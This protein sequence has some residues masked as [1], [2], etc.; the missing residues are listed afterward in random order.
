MFGHRDHTPLPSYAGDEHGS[1]QRAKN[2][3]EKRWRRIVQGLLVLSVSANLRIFYDA[4]TAWPAPLD[5]YQALNTYPIVDPKAFDT[6]APVNPR[7]HAVVTGLY[8]DAFATAVATLGHTLN[9]ANSSASRLLLYLPDKV[10]S[11]A[12]CI[13]SASGW[14]PVAVARIAPPAGGA[15]VHPHFL[16]QFSKLHLWALGRRAPG[17]RAVVYVDADALVRRAF[18]ELF[19][20]PH[21]F[22]AVPD[23]YADGGARTRGYTGAFNAGVLVLRPDGD[24]ALFADM[25]AKIAS[26]RFPAA[27]A[28]QAF[29]NHYFGM[30]ALRLPYAYNANLA[31]KQRTP[32]LW[33]S[34][35][36]EVRIQHFTV[37]KPFL[38][39][40]YAEVPMNDLEANAEAVARENPL[41]REEIFE[42][43]GAWKETRRTY[44][45]QLARCN[46]L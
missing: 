8:T 14:E 37:V 33:E 28:E 25:A 22:A 5:N 39:G 45:K 10:S 26:A 13:A 12:L 17:L 29:L 30:E 46:M 35:R 24:G 20:L 7:E 27:Q 34:L 21:T 6:L 3:H 23:V 38:Q 19:R 44:S 18:D 41:F 36:S 9:A 32:A 40:D 42:W 4:F 15:G 11:R 16:D 1:P 31:I 43:L 2:T